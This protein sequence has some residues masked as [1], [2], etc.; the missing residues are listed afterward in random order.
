MLAI[1]RA[2]PE[3]TMKRPL[4]LASAAVALL[5]AASAAEASRV[6]WSIGINVPPVATYVPSGPVWAPAPLRYASPAVVYSTPTSFYA[7][8]P[9]V[10]DEPYVYRS[11]A[12]PRVRYDVPPIVVAPR[13]RHHW[14]PP[15][16]SRWAPVHRA[17]W[18]RHDRWHHRFDHHR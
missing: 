7:P 3:D 11:Y 18:D 13:H 9:I 6:G 17:P 5:F 16:W 2:L 14:G 1:S 4:L 12:V 15:H 8:A 10:Y